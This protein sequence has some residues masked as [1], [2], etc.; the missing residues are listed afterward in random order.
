MVENNTGIS[1]VDFKRKYKNT[2]KFRQAAIY[3]TEHGYYTSAPYGSSDFKKYWDEE[4]DRCVNG[5]IASDGDYISG[6][7]YF[8][9]NYCPIQRNVNKITTLP[10]G[11]VIV[12]RTQDL[13]F[14]NFYDYDAYYYSAIEEAEDLGKHLCVLKSRR[15]GY[16]YKAASM[17]CR[18][19]YF[20]PNSKTYIYASKKE[21]LT[22]DGVLTKAWDYMSFIDEHTAWGKKRSINKELHR[23]AGFFTKDQ[24]GNEVEAGFKSEIIGVT[25]N[26]N[27]DVVRGKKAKLILF[28]EAGSFKELGA[29]WQIARPSVEDDGVAFGL[30]IAYGTG[31]DKD[32]NFATLKDMFYKPAAY[33]CLG[34]KNI[35]DDGI[36]DK[37]CGFFIPQSTNM[38]I[39]DR[40]TGKRIYM[41][42]DGNTFDIISR[43]KILEDREALISKSTSQTAVDRYIAERPL[44]PREAMLDLKGNIF[45]KKDL[46]EHL[47]NIRT[48]S[49][50]QA[51]KQVGDL[52][53]T[54]TGQ[55]VWRQKKFGDIL[56]YDIPDGEDKTGSIVIWEHPDPAAPF[57]LYIAGCLTPGEKVL[58]Q[59]GLVNVE[60]VVGSDKL[61][62]KY[63][64]L[65][66]IKNLQRY[67]KANDDTYRIKPCGSYRSTNF[68]GEHPI[69]IKD[70]GFVKARDIS[71][72]DILEIPNRYYNPIKSGSY[73]ERM[74]YYF[75]G[76]WLGDGFVNINGRSHDIYL[77]IG[78]DEVDLAD[79]YDRLIAKL[80]NRN[81]INVHKN[82]ELTR[83]FTHKELALFLKDNF[84]TSAY[85]KRVPEFV[86]KSKEDCRRCFIQG[87]L[88]SDGSVFYDR[89]NVR[90]N[91]TSVNL[92][93]LE[94]IQ[95]ILYSLKIRCSIVLHQNETKN[96]LLI[97]NDGSNSI[98]LKSYRINVARSDVRRL[99][100]DRVFCSRK[101]ILI[102]SA[103]SSGKSKMNISFS[104]DGTK[105]YL[106]IDNIICD[107]YSG[108]VYNFECETHT[109]MTRNILTHNCD[110]LSLAG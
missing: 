81:A 83:R 85:N 34:F 9:L 51:S 103:S 82:T 91:F 110:P 5:F 12:K 62:N 80:F 42:E 18:N 52:V 84:G 79:F 74:F 92:E 33:N 50:L 17:A 57:G 22:G 89:G 29:A 46:M 60:D 59:R 10:N 108:V 88:D 72:N 102:D 39:V 41:D 96:K 65:V 38:D 19:F 90:A 69:W 48:N 14:P 86:K 64:D 27:P 56:T 30:M 28:E 4:T 7:F 78:K 55:L 93:L 23:R 105:I 45:P 1:T 98:S 47:S 95:D 11:E 13:T 104:N 61:V 8:Y 106:G 76:L 101:Q 66:A 15:K 31:G 77:S 20:I 99:S 21:Y 36:S 70:K 25:L 40:H 58:T 2:D 35:W 109:F 37:P 73:N 44:T 3:F 63:G 16:S 87:Y 54:E 32:S 26:N 94:G 67:I 43:Q 49:K 24:Y 53:R 107:T 71:H 6:Y 75:L 68:T 97:N 100:E